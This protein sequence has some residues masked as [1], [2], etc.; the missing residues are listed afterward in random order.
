MLAPIKRR[1]KRAAR[2]MR[3]SHLTVERKS[4]PAKAFLIWDSKVSNLA[5]RTQPSGHKAWV[6]VY[7]RHGRSRWLTLGN[8]ST[9]PLED[10]RLKARKAMVRVG[11]GGD[12]AAEKRAERGAGTFA[13]L[14][15]K[16]VEQHAKK[17][18][19]SWQQADAL[20]RRFAI[21]RWGKLQASAIMRRDVRA[22]MTDITA[23]VLANNTLAAVSAIFSWGFDQEIVAAN[24]AKGIARNPTT[25]RERVLADSEVAPLWKA[26]DGIDPVRAAALRMVL[27]TG[28]R[29]GEVANM[30]R[31]HI[32]DGWWE[33]PGAPIPGVWPG[34]KNGEN[35]RVWLPKPVQ[36]LLAA[37]SDGKGSTGFVFASPRGGPVSKLDA[38]MRDVC[39]KLGIERATPHDLRRTFGTTIT[40][41]KFGRDAMN[42]ILNHST[43]DDVGDVYDRHGYHDD[44]KR[45][46]ETVAN[47]IMALAEGREPDDN[48]VRPDSFARSARG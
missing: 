45:V 4:R 6:V 21:P 27:I 33:M 41:L 9:I 39:A 17:H 24:P 38:A 7:S 44:D 31:E 3:I 32:K 48:I 12:P 36:D 43:N 46:M 16:Y 2:K 42:R 1:P 22:L 34:T 25:S 30:R 29:P 8:A 20:I 23:P 10:A 47:H 18:N 26:L 11:E 37:M 40:K 14:A 19:K 28:Q 15:A 35:H 5:L 13:E